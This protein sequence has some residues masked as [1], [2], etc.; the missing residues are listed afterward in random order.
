MVV[1]IFASVINNDRDLIPVTTDLYGRRVQGTPKKG[2]YI[3]N[4]KKAVVR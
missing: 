1:S 4:G 2:V 3:Q